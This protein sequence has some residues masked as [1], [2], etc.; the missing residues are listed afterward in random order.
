MYLPLAV[1]AAGLL[2]GTRR[3]ARGCLCS[4]ILETLYAPRKSDRR[5]VSGLAWALPTPCSRVSRILSLARRDP[6]VLGASLTWALATNGPKAARA[7]RQF[8]MT[9]AGPLYSHR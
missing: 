6:Q 4:S 9:N 1:G 2:A 5:R 8:P 3:G 7:A